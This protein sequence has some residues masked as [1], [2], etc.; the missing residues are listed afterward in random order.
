MKKLIINILVLSLP[1]F[2]WAQN[3]RELFEMS[4]EENTE[5]KAL[6][7][8][9]QASLEKAPQV[10]QLPNPEV[11]IGAFILPVETRLGSQQARL[12]ASQMFP[13][14]GSLKAKENWALA[15][16]QVKFEKIAS[17][18]LEVYYQIKTAWYQ[19]YLLEKKQLL[20]QKNVKLLHSLKSIA[21]AKV[22][23]GKASLA[24]VLRVDLKMQA[25]SKE[26][27]ILEMQRR[28]PLAVINQVLQRPLASPV[29]VKDSL[30]FS[31]IPFNKDTLLSEINSSHP[32]IRMFSRQQEVAQRAIEVN[33][34][35]GK[36]AFGVGADYLMVNPRSDAF[37]ERNGRDIVQ[38]KAVVS[39][40]LY[41]EKYEAKGREEALK[42]SAIENR[43]QEVL[44]YFLSRIEQAFA[45]NESALLQKELFEAQIQTTEAAIRILLQDYSNQ[46]R[47]FDELLRLEE[48]LIMYDIKLLE[49]IVRSHQSLAE[50]ERYLPY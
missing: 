49:A 22:I 42:I 13:W 8:E 19:L 18:E 15:A 40:P 23:S 27:E 16:A 34:M 35:E 5:L 48:E 38:I 12:S 44:T 11:G 9:Y 39:I 14:F 7:L 4:L 29:S 6:K 30:I 41:R 2:L 1:M 28:K 45:D 17:Q 31:A 37:P 26:I 25:L 36:P 20:I 24:D 50:V 32:M 47:N 21:E 3:P 43:K 33:E 10:S 46:G